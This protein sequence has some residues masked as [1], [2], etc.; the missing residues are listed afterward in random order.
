MLSTTH[1]SLALVILAGGV[2]A[3]TPVQGDIGSVVNYARFDIAYNDQVADM[4]E[5]YAAV[6]TAC[7]KEADAYQKR[8]KYKHPGNLEFDQ[9][10]TGVQPPSPKLVGYTH[11]GGNNYILHWQ[12]NGHWYER[13]TE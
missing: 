6:A 8:Y 3:Y 7:G 4:R 11:I 5:V 1:R 2:L 9:N 10:P 12:C 13:Y